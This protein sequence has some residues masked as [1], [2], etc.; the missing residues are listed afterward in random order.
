MVDRCTC[1]VCAELDLAYPGE[2]IQ[3]ALIDEDWIATTRRLVEQGRAQRQAEL[4]NRMAGRP[5]YN[6][7]RSAAG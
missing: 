1:A 3:L 6:P 4:A 5:A 7:M 2:G